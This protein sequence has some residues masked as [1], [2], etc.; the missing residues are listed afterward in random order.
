MNQQVLD[1]ANKI[2]MSVGAPFL[3]EVEYKFLPKDTSDL[4]GIYVGL[5]RILKRRKAPQTILDK[6]EAK[7]IL[8]DISITKE[9][10]TKRF[11]SNIILGFGV[12]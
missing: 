8:A 5:F 12:D 7:A 9:Q 3:V 1:I 11:G 2:L 10:A 6:L 4:Q